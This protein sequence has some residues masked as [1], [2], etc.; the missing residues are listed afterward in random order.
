MK[1]PQA[2]EAALL[3][4]ASLKEGSQ[5]VREEWLWYSMAECVHGE[6]ISQLF[7]PGQQLDLQEQLHIQVSFCLQPWLACS[8]RIKRAHLDGLRSYT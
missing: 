3:P 5:P 8:L 6:A 4:K 7:R 1:S 2:C